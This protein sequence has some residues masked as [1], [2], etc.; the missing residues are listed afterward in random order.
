MRD[1]GRRLLIGLAVVAA[2]VMAIGYAFIAGRI[3][4]P[5]QSDLGTFPV[6]DERAA[7][8]PSSSPMAGPHSSWPREGD[9]TS[10][11]P[12]DRHAPGVA[13]PPR[14]VVRR[15]DVRTTWPGGATYAP[16]GHALAAGPAR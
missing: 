6:P 13:G 12:A 4:D 10:S 15:H 2:A 9:L 16:D 14:R 3:A 8:R 1:L 7:R 11:T 5:I